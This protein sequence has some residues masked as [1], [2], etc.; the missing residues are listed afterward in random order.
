MFKVEVLLRVKYKTLTNVS[1]EN[2]GVFLLSTFDQFNR[3]IIGF[4]LQNFN[5]TF[6]QMVGGISK[7]FQRGII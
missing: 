3:T 7:Q 1:I 6:D 5:T 2:V 4:L